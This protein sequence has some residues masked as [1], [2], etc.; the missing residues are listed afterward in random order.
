M[1]IAE[2]F[3]AIG[4]KIEGEAELKSFEL[5]LR[6]IETACHGVISALKQLGVLKVRVPR[7]PAP[8]AVPAAALGGPAGTP[9]PASTA[10]ST[11][12]QEKKR[13]EKKAQRTQSML[14]G[15]MLKATL[16]FSTVMGG[17]R[18]FAEGI[19]T[20]VRSSLDLAQTQDHLRVNAALSAKDFQQWSHLARISG[21]SPEQTAGEVAALQKK[22]SSYS[23]GFEVP[24]GIMSWFAPGTT[25]T[26]FLKNFA[27]GTVGMKET[28]A[29]SLAGQMGISDSMFYALRRNLENLDDVL[30][31]TA[32]EDQYK[33]LQQINVEWGKFNDSMSRATVLLTAV[34]SPAIIAIVQKMSG[35]VEKI[36]SHPLDAGL[37]AAA[38]PFGAVVAGLRPIL[39]VLQDPNH[40]RGP[41]QLT[42]VQHI[43]GS[44]DPKIVA[45]ESSRAFY[46]ESLKVR[47]TQPLP[48]SNR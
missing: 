25:A 37:D 9:T 26:Q 46:R 24:S 28:D 18:M 48:S 11:E 30:S 35:W 20:A 4:V 32:N 23:M 33:Q 6:A 27:R 45:D 13:E 3:A 7:I 10:L 44:G 14:I 38:I 36:P 22:L 16:G 1:K 42:V 43:D 47:Y 34:A 17:V 19:K 40:Y 5:Q 21:L 39:N 41:S 8:G 12:E 29:L 15:A 31:N 2:L